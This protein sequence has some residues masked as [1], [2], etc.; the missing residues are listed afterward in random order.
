MQLNL[1]PYE[2]KV[3]RKGD[4]DQIFCSFRQKYVALTPEEWVRQHF[5]HYLVRHLGYAAGRLVLEGSLVVNGIASRW[6]VLAY[7][8]TGKPFLL[9]E[10]KAP[11]VPLTQKVFDQAYRYYVGT[12]APWVAVTNGLEHYCLF[13]AGGIPQFADTLPKPE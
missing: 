3:I 1:P 8:Q 12:G 4:S 7:T 2:A 13:N 9:V 6:D 5:C 10:C 11:Q